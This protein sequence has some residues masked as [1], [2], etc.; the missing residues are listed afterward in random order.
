MK[1]MKIDVNC[2]NKT[3]SISNQESLTTHVVGAKSTELE[4][5]T[6]WEVFPLRLPN[7]KR[8]NVVFIGP[9]LRW[10]II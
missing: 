10:D 4:D 3:K 6:I 7:L 9:Q 1:N 8:M 2:G 5:V